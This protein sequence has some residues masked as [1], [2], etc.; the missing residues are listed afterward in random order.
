MKAAEGV[1]VHVPVETRPDRFVTVRVTGMEPSDRGHRVKTLLFKAGEWYVTIGNVRYRLVAGHGRA[2]ASSS[3]YLRAPMA[4][5]LFAFGPPIETTVD[6]VRPPGKA[7]SRHDML[8]Y[9][10]LSVPVAAP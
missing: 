3:P 5:G 8:T 7:T 2:M 4:R 1:A 9:E 6:P 10:F